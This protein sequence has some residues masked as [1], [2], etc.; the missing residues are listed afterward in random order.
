MEQRDIRT[1]LKGKSPAG[2]RNPGQFFQQTPL[3]SLLPLHPSRAL[4]SVG[5]VAQSP[6]CVLFAVF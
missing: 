2:C 5:P 4:P 1:V 6:D 3:V